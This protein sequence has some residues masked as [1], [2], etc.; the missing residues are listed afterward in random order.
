MSTT[1]DRAEILTRLR[2]AVRYM[3]TDHEIEW[4]EPDPLG[5]WPAHRKRRVITLTIHD[6]ATFEAML[7]VRCGETTAACRGTRQ[8]HANR[9][10]RRTSSTL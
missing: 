5:Q 8:P 2:T 6:P 7:R 4:S 9:P 1:N 3:A 10:A